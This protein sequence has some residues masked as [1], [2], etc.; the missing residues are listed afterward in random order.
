MIADKIISVA[1]ILIAG[2][3]YFKCQDGRIR[4]EERTKINKET[5]VLVKKRDKERNL[6]ATNRQ[7]IIDEA[8]DKIKKAKTWDDKADIIFDSWGN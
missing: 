4:K 1:L 6:K 7:E 8:K 5:E 2:I 3:V